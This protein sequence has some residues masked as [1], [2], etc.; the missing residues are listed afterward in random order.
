MT[1]DKVRVFAAANYVFVFLVRK[2]FLTLAALVQR[3]KIITECA[4]G[5]IVQPPEWTE[6]FEH[7]G[8]HGW[9]RD[10]ETKT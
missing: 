10:W 9:D 4:V 1:K 3:N 2:Y 7:I 8:K 6:L 5:T